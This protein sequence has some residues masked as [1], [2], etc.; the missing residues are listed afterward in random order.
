MS[1]ANLYALSWVFF[2]SLL[3]FFS[4]RLSCFM[5]PPLLLVMNVI[6]RL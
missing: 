2:I 1:R 3:Y 5:F 6:R 4:V